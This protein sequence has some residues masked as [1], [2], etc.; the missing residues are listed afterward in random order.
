MHVG[1]ITDPG[2]STK[3]KALVFTIAGALLAATLLSVRFGSAQG[4]VVFAFIPIC[5]ALWCAGDLLTGFLLYAHYRVTGRVALLVVA[6]AY[7]LT[8]LFSVPYLAAFPGI[9]FVA[10]GLQQISIWL[11]LCWHTLFPL[12]VG[13]YFLIDPE[14]RARFVDE[15]SIERLGWPAILGVTAVV[16]LISSG[17]WLF[18]TRLP[19]L[20]EAGHFSLSYSYALAPLMVAI[21]LAA[22]VAIFVRTRQPTRLHAWLA[23]ALFTNALDSALNAITV[24]RYSLAWYV[25][26][27]ETLVMATL[28]LFVLLQE[29]AVLY[30][31]ISSLAML[32]S[33][34]GLRNR[35]SFDEAAQWMLGMSKRRGWPVAMLMIDI[36]HFKRFNDS[37]GHNVGDEC[38]KG[39]AA[40]LRR[41]LSRDSDLVARYGG[42]EFVAMLVDISAPGVA[43]IAERLRRAVRESAGPT[44][45]S[46]TISVGMTWT[47]NADGVVDIPRLIQVADA[48]L[49]QAKSR[50][51]DRCVMA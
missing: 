38:L 6:C 3:S 15:R 14:L 5:A 39:V 29:L 9:F 35:R 33:L 47:G 45:R 46:V 13:T 37:F 25:G 49:Y 51:R 1:T 11:W 10:S 40:A 23:L 36:D 43:Q 2:V 44:D 18:H 4:P 19:H 7:L 16:A 30:K 22:A 17:V 27:V 20:V 50:G 21:S 41:E 32:D 24:S 42:D 8:G 12:I 26:K 31:Q 48:A 34:T 28:L